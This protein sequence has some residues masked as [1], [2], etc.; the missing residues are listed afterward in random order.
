ME[1]GEAG[2]VI[3]PNLIFLHSSHV[4]GTLALIVSQEDKRQHRG[5]GTDPVGRGQTDTLLDAQ[6]PVRDPP[7]APAGHCH[8]PSGRALAGCTV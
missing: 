2:M 1:K 4:D 6:R 3:P 8:T 5:E 7:R